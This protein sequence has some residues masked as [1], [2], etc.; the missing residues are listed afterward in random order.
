MGDPPPPRPV[1][2]V[3]DACALF[4]AALRDIIRRAGEAGLLVPLWSDRILAEWVHAA[5]RDG[6]AAA[7]QAGAGAFSAAFPGGRVALPEG[8]EQ[9]LFLPDPADRHV[10]AAAI[11]GRAEAIVTFNTRD[12]PARILAGYGI[13]CR[14]PDGF[15]WELHSHAPEAVA[16]IV[17]EARAAAAGGAPLSRQ[18]LLRRLHLHRLARALADQGA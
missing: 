10:L 1:R 16:R 18:R 8:L 2:A 5:G 15:L 14:H 7:A 9:G 3:I 6:A 13:A 17:E 4:P 12:F 11:A